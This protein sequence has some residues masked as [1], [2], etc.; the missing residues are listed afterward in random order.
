MKSPKND[1]HDRLPI[2]NQLQIL[3]LDTDV[4]FSYEAIAKVCASS[5][6]SLEELEKILFNEVL[7]ALRFNLWATP[8]PEWAYFDQQWLQ[9]RI[10]SH[11]RYNKSKPILFRTYTNQHWQIIKSKIQSCRERQIS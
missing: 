9:T 10:L 7:P 5:K 4:T 2:W 3:Y 1:L 8:I 11:H 6:Y